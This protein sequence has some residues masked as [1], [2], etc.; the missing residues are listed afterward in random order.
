[1]INLIAEIG[2]NHKGSFA[3]AKDL[4]DQAA[5]AG[6]WAVKFQFR[7]V[8][9][10]YKS[11]SEIGD[12]ILLQEIKRTNLTVQELTDLAL[13]AKSLG[14]KAGVSF[15]RYQDFQIMGAGVSFFDFF[16]VPSAECTNHILIEKLLD[17]G[18][19]VMVSTG[20]HSLIDVK[21]ALFQ[22]IGKDLVIFHCVANYPTK[23]GSQNLNFIHDL[24]D[25]GFDH[26]GYSSH[27]EDFENCIIAMSMG[28]Q[29]IE[30]HLTHD[31]SGC[32]LDDSSSSEITDF[33]KLKSF[34]LQMNN[35][36]G[37]RNRLPNQG[38][39]LNMQNLGTGLYSKLKIIKGSTSILTNF[40]AKAPRVGLSTGDYLLYYQN[41]ALKVDL[42]VGEALSIRHFQEEKVF[43]SPT[44]FNFASKNKIGIPVRLHDFED[45]SSK[46]KTGVYEFHLSYGEVLS[47]NLHKIIDSIDSEDFISL[48]LPD[49]LSGNRVIDPISDNLNTR[50]DSQ[51]IIQRSLDFAKALSDKTNKKIP[52]V[53]SFSQRSN[54]GRYEVLD[55]LF[56]YIDSNESDGINIYPQWLPIYAWYFGGSVK[57]E[58]MNSEKDINYIVKH[59]RKICLDLCHL[60]LSAKYF[61]SN[62]KDWY[63][64][65]KPFIGHLHFA[66]S[67]G[68][69]GEGLDIGEGDIGDFSIFLD[70]PKMKIIEVWQGHHNEGLGFMKA[71][72]K[73]FE[74]EYK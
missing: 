1:M 37:E 46:I 6:C 55:D 9:S 27:D 21:K 47:D 23:L 11:C 66:D 35:I 41:K 72:D 38:E 8:D 43:D 68:V 40:E 73:L 20:G 36:L 4:V 69:D 33:I 3:K 48:H 14:L 59:S 67:Q 64:L 15:F 18:K 45:F 54:R 16:K 24:K 22:F 26:V 71:L 13:H 61:N 63:K 52:V 39:I 51:L 32:G 5:M 60:A 17:T 30:R 28:V 70:V 56:S 57:L 34:S 42:N 2:I 50:N 19:K 53:G 62:W 31:V 25:I 10:F 74:Q 29:W 44:L 12:E 58:L 49:Y 7:D 65:L